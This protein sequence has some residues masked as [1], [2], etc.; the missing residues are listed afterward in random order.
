MTDLNVHDALDRATGHLDL[1]PGLLDRVRAGGRRRVVRRRTLLGAGLA[2][3]TAGSAAGVWWRP[4]G[5]DAMP[6]SIR[7]DR[8]TRGDLAGDAA[9]LRQVRDAWRAH[10]GDQIRT[11]GEPHVVWAGRTP[12]GPVALVAQRTPPRVA[13][14]IGQVEFGLTGF[15]EQRAGRPAAGNMETMLSEA[16]NS[17]A[18]LA[19]PDRTVLVVVDEDRP[20]SFSPSLS[21]DAQG[22]PARTFRQLT[23][24]DGASVTSVAP[25]RDTVA[26]GLRSGDE[27]VGL[28]NI[29]EILDV[30][31]DPMPALIRR[32]PGARLDV[33]L[34]SLE[35]YQDRY[36]YPGPPSVASWRIS[37][38]A[39][40][41]LFVVQT[42][43]TGRTVRTFVCIDPTPRLAGIAD[44]DPQAPPSLR[45]R[46]P[47]NLGFVVAAESASLAYRVGSGDWI[48][49]IGDAALLPPAATEYRV[50][51][52]GR[53]AMVRLP[54]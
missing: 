32:L 48:P 42:L 35:D 49:V 52:Q 54:D 40:S 9:Y 46:L 39:G 20:V 27:G 3:A 43:V 29:S 50:V 51:R 33:D 24:R 6:A 34:V 1:P 17:P 44:G 31:V 45:V 47:E 13:S 38:A 28:A 16:V 25:Q 53:P 7:F 41:R 30:R 18:F 4:G 36:G 15:V 22:R 12:A 8:A 11:V 10:V 19:G 5:A 2:V 37:G 14:P 26:I 21:W 23:Y